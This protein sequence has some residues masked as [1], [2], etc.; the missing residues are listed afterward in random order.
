MEVKITAAQV[1][2]LRKAT[3][4]GMMDCKKALVE[5]EGDF[6][7]AVDLLRKKG[8]KVAAKRADRAANEGRVIAKVNADS[9]KA[10]ILVMGCET[11]FVAKN[12]EFVALNEKIIN[13][14]MAHDINT[15]EE[16]LNY[17]FDG[18]TVSEHL[19][20]LTG[21]TGE[22]LEIPA[23]NVLSAPHVTAYNHNG[24]RLGVIAGFNM[25]GFEETTHEV[26]LQIAAMNPA[27]LSADNIS[28][29]TKAHELAVIIEKTKADEIAKAVENAIR[30][31]G[32]NPAHVDSDDHIESNM[33]KGWITPEQ[34]QQARE[35]KVKAT[36][37]ATANLDKQ[38]KKIEMIS[39]GRLQKYYKE[40]TLLAQE[41]YGDSKMNVAEFMK[42]A[43]A[44]LTCTAYYRLQLGD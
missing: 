25:P 28:E 32:I 29:E 19:I 4:V 14:A 43:N 37:E 15:L 41:Y 26:A 8:Q 18:M 13:E 35:I 1:N 44:E 2:E 16:L 31:A 21:K 11:D 30:K 39:Q 3:G 7:K 22:K 17:T 12:E 27:A 9:T 23:Y 38:A 36:E 33:K 5:A 20:Q 24:N 6:E 34:A 40:N 42:K 10:Y